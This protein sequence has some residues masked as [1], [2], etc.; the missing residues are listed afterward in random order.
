MLDLLITIPEMGPTA[1]RD[2]RRIMTQRFPYA[3]YYRLTDTAIEI[4]AVLH[5]R[6]NP[7]PG[8]RR[9]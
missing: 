6:R 8:Y 9:A 3:I 4:R 2:L 1:Y 5:H 7:P